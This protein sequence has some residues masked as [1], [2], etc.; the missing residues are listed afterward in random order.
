MI[1]LTD[2]RNERL[3][4]KRK[5]SNPVI[6]FVRNTSAW[7]VYHDFL[8]FNY[9]R[10]ISSRL[11]WNLLSPN[12]LGLKFLETMSSMLIHNFNFTIQI[13]HNTSISIFSNYI[14]FFCERTQIAQKQAVYI[15]FLSPADFNK[16]IMQCAY[17]IGYIFVWSKR[18]G[19]NNVKCI[20]IYIICHI[21]VFT[22]PKLQQER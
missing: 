17:K 11:R 22:I 3:I 1:L 16:F 6:R 14:R 7:T 4:W 8:Y 12:G 19:E 21:H 9:L 2:E 10:R 20:E 15:D 18:A 13:D 5:T